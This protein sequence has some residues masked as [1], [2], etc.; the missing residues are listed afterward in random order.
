MDVVAVYGLDT[1]DSDSLKILSNRMQA[2]HKKESFIMSCLRHFT[3][4]TFQM[5]L[6]CEC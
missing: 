2:Y 5:S 6:T 4:C 1:M 3:D